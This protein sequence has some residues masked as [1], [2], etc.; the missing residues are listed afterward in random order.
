MFG[1]YKGFKKGFLMETANTLAFLLAIIGGFQLLQWGMDLLYEHFEIHGN[2]LPYVSF[3]T[4]FIG[5]ILL[6]NIIGRILKKVVHMILLGSLDTFA[7]G[8]IG[9]LKWT[10]GISVM[11]WLSTKIGLLV[12]TEYINDSMLYPYI[13]PIAPMVMEYVTIF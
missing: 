12:P 4:I 2:L 7:G 13:A 10:F 1:A 11:L 9:L 8:V 6:V 5:I 3:I